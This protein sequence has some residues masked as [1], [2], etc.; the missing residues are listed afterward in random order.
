MLRFPFLLAAGLLVFT[1]RSAIADDIGNWR[2]TPPNREAI[3]FDYAGNRLYWDDNGMIAGR[4][5]YA[6]QEFQPGAFKAARWYDL[7]VKR[8]TAHTSGFDLA[9][10]TQPNVPEKKQLA[11][12]AANVAMTAWAT[13]SPRQS[14]RD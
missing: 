7:T 10:K 1:A 6:S 9:G 14:A 3:A 12:P 13:V 8:G 11:G 2:S 5:D 4:Y